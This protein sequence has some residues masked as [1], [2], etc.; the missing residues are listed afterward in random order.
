ARVQEPEDA[1][2]TLRRALELWRGSPLT[3]VEYETWAWQEIGRLEELR[4]MAIED[5]IDAELQL[6]RR[7]IVVAELEALVAEH[8]L[9][10][11]LRGLL[12]LALYRG[13]R[14]AEA[15]EAYA[16]ARRLLD[17]DL[18]L[19]PSHELKELHR[20]ILLQDRSLDRPREVSVAGP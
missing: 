4:L 1:V 16:E 15:L 10:E 17:E 3:E 18:G 12:M 20:L 5:R 11:R 9:R 19:E 7:Q 8:P 6:G 13:G 14:Q 2:R